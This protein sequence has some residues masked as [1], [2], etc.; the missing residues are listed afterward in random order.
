VEVLIYLSKNSDPH[1][2]LLPKSLLVTESY[3]VV[4]YICLLCKSR[5]L[6]GP[7]KFKSRTPSVCLSSKIC[8]DEDSNYSPS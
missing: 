8:S 4:R 6:K 1:Q 2:R 7:Q 5:K 3:R